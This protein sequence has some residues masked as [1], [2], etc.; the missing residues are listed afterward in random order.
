VYVQVPKFRRPL[1]AKTPNFVVLW[2]SAFCGVTSWR[3][4]EKIEHGCTTA[5]LSLSNG[6]KS[7]SVLQRLHGEI[8]RTISH[9]HKRDGQTDKPTD[10]LETVSITEPLQN[11]QNHGSW[12]TWVMGKSSMGHLGHGSL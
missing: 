11:R 9:V 12:V 3:Q 10:K 1:A 2:N 7:V 8:G 6:I 4:S 5:D